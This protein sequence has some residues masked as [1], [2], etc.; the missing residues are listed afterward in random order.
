MADSTITR[1]LSFEV[2]FAGWRRADLEGKPART[3]GTADNSLDDE[4]PKQNKGGLW[5]RLAQASGELTEAANRALTALYAAKQGLLPVP[6]KGGKPVSL[7]TLSYQAF[8][9]KWQPAGRPLYAPKGRRVGANVLLGT[10]SV[11][12]ARLI[13]DFGEVQR[14]KKSLPTFRSLPFLVVGAGVRIRPDTGLV[15]IAL[16]EGRSANT[17]TLQPVCLDSGSREVFSRIRKGTYKLG[18]AKLRRDD[19]SHKWFLALSWTGPVEEKPR[20]RVCGVDL[21]FLARAHLCYLDP[22]TG[23][24]ARERDWV[25]APSTTLRAIDAVEAA[26][27]ERSRF[28][29]DEYDART[30]HGRERK[31]RAVQALVDRRA[32]IAK[33]ATRQVAAA[34]VAQALARGASV[35]VVE[36]LT[37]FTADKMAETAGLQGRARARVRKRFM[38]WQ[39]GAIRAAV[40]VAAKAAGMQFVAVNPAHSSRTCCKC[41]KVYREQGG[42]FGLVSFTRFSCECGN[43][44]FAPWNAASVLAQRGWAALSAAE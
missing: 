38:C 3:R 9:G 23:V 12:Y 22:T 27:R 37:G 43:R 29:R 33:A 10:A 35:L 13:A 30:G 7:Q 28:N 5:Y 15:D 40:E 21:R 18:D 4:S 20:G 14:G 41:G 26:R 44:L 16:W 39:Q 19:Q 32:N 2:R 8:S 24:L 25:A 42:E 34:I 1:T 31:H 6:E 36:N 11:V 17:L